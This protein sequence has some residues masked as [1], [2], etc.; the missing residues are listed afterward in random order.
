MHDPQVLRCSLELSKHGST[1]MYFVSFLNKMQS[2]FN[3]LV[4]EVK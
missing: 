4:R 1:L 2:L 3:P